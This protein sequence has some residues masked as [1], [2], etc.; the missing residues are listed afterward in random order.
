MNLL[1]VALRLGA[2]PSV[3]GNHAK[4]NLGGFEV[5]HLTCPQQRHVEVFVGFI[6]GSV[7]EFVLCNWIT[8][9]LGEDEFVYSA[10]YFGWKLRE[11]ETGS[12]RITVLGCECMKTCVNVFRT[13]LGIAFCVLFREAEG[14]EVRLE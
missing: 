12:L 11:E 2:P 10:A 6:V 4:R 1:G 13:A 8:I 7:P 5:Y 9:L 3:D 14:T